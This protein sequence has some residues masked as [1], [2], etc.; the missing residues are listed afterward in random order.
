MRAGDLGAGI[1]ASLILLTAPLSASEAARS[2]PNPCSTFTVSSLD[3]LLGLPTS[4]HPHRATSRRGASYR[5]CTA[6]HHAHYFQAIVEKQKP[7]PNQ[8]EVTTTYRRPKL[9]HDGEIIVAKK[10]QPGDTEA[11]FKRRG[12]WFDDV[13]SVSLPHKGKR[14]Y[15]FALAQSSR[16]SK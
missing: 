1:C 16:Y 15:T 10:G 7:T 8:F 13:Y 12:I 3:A 4:D 6:A 9:G 2:L 14:M 5:A 11:V